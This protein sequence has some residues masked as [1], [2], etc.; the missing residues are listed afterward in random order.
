[1]MVLSK[2]LFVTMFV[3]YNKTNYL[4]PLLIRLVSHEQQSY[5]EDEMHRSGRAGDPEQE[6]RN[7]G[8]VKIG[9]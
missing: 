9:K 6:C 3:F 5:S 1:M 2:C 4:F 8:F 7:V